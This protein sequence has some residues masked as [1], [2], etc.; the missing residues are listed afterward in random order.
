MHAAA[1]YPVWRHHLGQSVTLPNDTTPGTVTQADYDV[2]RSHFGQ[3]AG[4][5][6][7]AVANA[8]IPEPT[9]MVMLITAMLAKYSRRHSLVVSCAHVRA[10][11]S[12][13]H[14]T[15]QMM[16]AMLRTRRGI[17]TG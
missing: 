9:T 6:S 12:A 17:G 4:S 1:D 14:A 3:T 11:I 5:G 2:W 13:T 15:R 10:G 7:G 16:D 8:A